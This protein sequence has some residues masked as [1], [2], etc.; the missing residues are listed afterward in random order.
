MNINEFESAEQLNNAFAKKLLADLQQGIDTK[1]HAVLAVSGGGTPKGLFKLLSQQS[2]EWNK[3]TVTLVDDRWVNTDEDASNEK[4]VKAHLLVNKAASANFV[5]LVA[6]N[7]LQHSSAFDGQAAVEQKVGELPL[8]FDAV[9]LG[10]GEDGHT[11]SLFPCSEQII[12]GL[13]PTNNALTIAV[14]PK[15]A[16]HQRISFTFAAL[17]NS[18]KLYLH[19]VG[20]NKR[21]VLQQAMADNNSFEMP[22][23]AF[24]HQTDTPF[25]VMFAAK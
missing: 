6:D 17:I 22:I 12:D 4:L 8:P 14:E 10:M 18:Q 2:F 9:I 20:E 23:R 16:P 15:T 13:S 24:I 11:A 21:S 7:Y 19:I 3:V 1:G 25:E 5:G